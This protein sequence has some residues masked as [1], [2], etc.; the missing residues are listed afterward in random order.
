MPLPSNNN[1][2]SSILSKTSASKGVV[3]N[4]SGLTLPNAAPSG[5]KMGNGASASNITI[6]GEHIDIVKI[7]TLIPELRKE[8]KLRDARLQKYEN[9][10]HEKT[11]LLA[12]KSDE[13]TKLNAEV[14]KLKSVLQIKV[15]KD[16]GKPDIL[17]TIQEDATMAGQE[18]R[19]KKQ[20]VSG[21]SPMSSQ[22]GVAVEIKHFEKEF[23]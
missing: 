5:A 17:A 16:A 2:A 15:H 20:G 12:E 7:R 23:R 11:K 4:P 9:E 14:D 10:L 22:N 13:I 8:I 6:E 21:E 3:K 18:T 1:K 19:A